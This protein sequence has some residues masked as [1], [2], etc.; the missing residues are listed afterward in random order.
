MNPYNFLLSSA[1]P[2]L[3][4]EL[5]S[6]IAHESAQ[7]S[8]WRRENDRRRHDFT[9]LALNLLAAMA[10]RGGL[11]EGFKAAAELSERKAKEAKDNKKNKGGLP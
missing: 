11:R 6:C 4:S 8:K 1:P 5:E 7:R 3:R 10:K 9:P 2:T